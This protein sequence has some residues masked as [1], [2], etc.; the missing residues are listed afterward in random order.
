MERD[1]NRWEKME[2]YYSTD[3]SS[4]WVV[5]PIEE[6]EDDLYAD[7]RVIFK[8]ILMQSVARS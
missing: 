4:Q 6:E 8:C 2:G 3:Q 7:G 1:G 5:V